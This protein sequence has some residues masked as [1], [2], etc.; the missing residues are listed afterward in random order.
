MTDYELNFSIKIEQML[1]TINEP[2]YRQIVV[3]VKVI[4]C[5]KLN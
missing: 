2:V 3:E 1:N 5:L 4:Y